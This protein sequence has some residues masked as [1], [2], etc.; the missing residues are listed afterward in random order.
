LASS[1]SVGLTAD[2][3]RVALLMG[4][5]ADVGGFEC[6]RRR[7][8]VPL[9]RAKGSQRCGYAMAFFGRSSGRL[10]LCVRILSGVQVAPSYCVGV[11]PSETD[12]GAGSTRSP[13]LRRAVGRASRNAPVS[14]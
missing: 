3:R 4:V 11:T 6:R 9:W 14:V 5:L 10:K 2:C 12:D 8:G 7:K 13:A 1:T